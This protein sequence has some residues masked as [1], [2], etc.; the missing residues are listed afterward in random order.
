MA[1]PVELL[2]LLSLKVAVAAVQLDR[3]GMVELAHLQVLIIL[4]DRV[5]VEL[6]TQQSQQMAMSE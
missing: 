3:V 4:A 5:V 6:Q 1:V 2:V